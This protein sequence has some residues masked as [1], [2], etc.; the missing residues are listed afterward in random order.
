MSSFLLEDEIY[1]EFYVLEL[2]LDI[3]S[4]P[5]DVTKDLLFYPPLF[6]YVYLISLFIILFPFAALEFT[7]SENFA[8]LRTD[9]G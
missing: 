5:A 4:A 3:I 8:F 1:L 2:L 6:Y 9:V 7:F